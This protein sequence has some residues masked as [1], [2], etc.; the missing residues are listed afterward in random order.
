VTRDTNV[1][2][3]HQGRHSGARSWALVEGCASPEAITPM[4]YVS[5]PPVVMASELAG[6]SPRPGMTVKNVI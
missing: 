2:C 6:E 5:F 1:H 3:D 4:L